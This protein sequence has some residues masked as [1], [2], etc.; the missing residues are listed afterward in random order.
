MLGRY[1]ETRVTIER[2]VMPQS[3]RIC[4][5][6]D[7][8]EFYML[9]HQRW[10]SLEADNQAEL[11]A[12]VGTSPHAE[13]HFADDITWV[14]TGVLSNDYN[15]VLW[16]RLPDA[17]ANQVIA[18]IVDQ[19]RARNVPALWHIDNESQPADLAQRLESFGCHRL[20]PGVCMVADLLAINETGRVIPGLTIE[21]VVNEGSLAAWMDVWMQLDDGERAPRERLYASL[22]FEHSGPLHHYLARLNGQP[23]AVSQLFLGREAA[24]LYCVTTLSEARRRGIGTAI[25]LGPLLEARARGYRVAVLGPTPQSQTMYQRIGFELYDSSFVGYTL[26]IDV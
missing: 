25:I 7:R 4:S 24:G 18:S 20:N 3:L 10:S 22:G 12:Y 9:D 17:T 1:P 13:S 6:P 15:G 8:K 14:I 11:L 21:R 19:F 16:A 23:V 5:A 2:G 26:W